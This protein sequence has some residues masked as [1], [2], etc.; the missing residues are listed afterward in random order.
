[1]DKSKYYSLL[2]K[3]Y[4]RKMG[5]VSKIVGLTVES[6]GPDAK[7][8]DVCHIILKDRP[9]YINA[10]VVGFKD[11]R[12]ILMPFENMDG[13]GPGCIVENT[14]ET[15][16]VKVCDELLGKTVDGLGIPIDGTE[17][18]GYEKYPVD[19]TPPDPMDRIIINEVL[20]LGVKAVDGLLTIGK[21]QRIGIFAGSGVG[22]STL[23]G[24]F[25]IGRAHV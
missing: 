19:Q 3:T 23:M 18:V 6:I 10:E 12:I 17:L 15:L 8:N 2:N 22:K 5:K 24:M 20:P 4:Y 11:K 25:E 13:I 1:M 21:G 14:N 16:S 7:L 9:G